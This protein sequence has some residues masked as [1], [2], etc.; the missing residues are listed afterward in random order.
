MSDVVGLDIGGSKTAGRRVRDGVVVGEAVAGS[1]NLQSVSRDE[2]RTA[3]R[4]I[5]VALGVGGGAG[6]GAGDSGV[7]A[8]YAGSAG[9]DTPVTQEPVAALVREAFPGATVAVGH[10]TSLLLPAAGL[11]SGIAIIAGT[12][13]VAIGV[14][15][16][17]TT[18]RA[19]GWGHLLGDE[20]SGYWLG[21]MAVRHT[22]RRADLGEPVDAIGRATLAHG[23]VTR[24]LDLIGAFYDGDGVDRERWGRLGGTLV[25]LAEHDAAAAALVGE[26]VGD[27]VGLWRTVATRLEMSGPVLLC[28]GLHTRIAQYAAAVRVGLTDAGAQ[29]V[30]VLEEEPVA[31]AVVLARQIDPGKP[32]TRLLGGTGGVST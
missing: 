26:A 18:V 8:V 11:P 4:D 29:D 30:R 31:G 1:A 28:G 19:G 27:V 14:G 23:R 9:A 5:A 22:L 25:A 17:G 12:G 32:R 2:A 13:S 24:P 16:D 20:G 3:L 10:D 7:E 21:R 15:P 6:G